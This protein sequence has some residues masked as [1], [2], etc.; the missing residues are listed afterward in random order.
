[1]CLFVVLICCLVHDLFVSFIRLFFLSISRSVGR[2]LGELDGCCLFF[3]SASSHNFCY[4]F[5]FGKTT[6]SDRIYVN[7]PDMPKGKNGDIQLLSFNSHNTEGSETGEEN[8]GLDT[9][10][11]EDEPYKN[12]EL[13]TPGDLMAFAWQISQG[14]V[15]RS[16]L[17]CLYGMSLE[18]QKVLM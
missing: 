13:L 2:S 7:A 16:C 1:M 11:K 18:L 5:F 3:F 4:F 10:E 14:M 17:D 15:S 6:K 9:Q 12:E 8:K